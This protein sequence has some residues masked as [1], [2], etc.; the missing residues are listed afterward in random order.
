M[1]SEDILLVLKQV[2]DPRTGQDLPSLGMIQDVTVEDK[3][4]NLSIVIKGHAGNEKTSMYQNTVNLLN[5]AYPDYYVNVHFKK[6]SA[7]NPVFASPTPQIRNIVAVAS[8]KGGVG[9]S[10]MSVNLAY[11]LKEAGMRVGLVDADLYG[12]S[13]PTMLNLVGQRHPVKQIH[14]KHKLIPLEAYGIPVVSIGNVIDPEQAIVLRGPRLG[15]IIKQ[16]FQEVIWPEL[17]V[18]VVDLPPGTGDIQLTM[19]QTVPVTGVIMVTTPQQV[20]VADAVKAMNMFLLENIDVPILG[21]IE[22][23]SWFTPEE[24]PDN[25]YEI[26]GKGGGERLANKGN[27][28]LLGQMPLIMS[29]RE[30]GDAGKPAYMEESGLIKERY[31]QIAQEF[32]LALKKRNA[33]KAPTNPVEIKTR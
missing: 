14:G 21:V 15:G 17:D 9:K 22:N 12:P 6:A 3:V 33:N 32:I 5:Q 28:R 24:L 11:A 23:M 26:F 27:T 13:I 29:M 7:S 19:V 18:L 1:K 4:I 16:F 2:L 20:A 31:D 30:Q 25:R 8:G 10:T